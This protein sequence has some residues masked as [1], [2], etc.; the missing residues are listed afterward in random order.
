MKMGVEIGLMKAQAKEVSNHQKL[1]RGR[2][3][4]FLRVFIGD[5]DT[6]I[7]DFSPPVL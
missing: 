2:E 4:I 6:L 1:D 3:H 7:L 5:G